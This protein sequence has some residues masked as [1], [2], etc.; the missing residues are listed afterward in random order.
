MDGCA[1]DLLLDA[2][3]RHARGLGVTVC[4]RP[5]QPRRASTAA[6]VAEWRCHFGSF[7]GSH[8]QLDQYF[9]ISVE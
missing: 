7:R 8:A 3:V 6:D 1:V 9:E 4:S 5:R 2:I